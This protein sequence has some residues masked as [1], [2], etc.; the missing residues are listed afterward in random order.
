MDVKPVADDDIPRMRVA[1]RI[2]REVLD[3][4]IRM[5][6]PGIKTADIDRVVHEATIAELISISPE[7][8]RIP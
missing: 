2:A 6:E 5:V 8:P 1:G 7:L 3:T 4:A